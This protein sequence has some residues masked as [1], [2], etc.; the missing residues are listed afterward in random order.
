MKIIK[1]TDTVNHI[2]GGQL[3]LA[4]DSFTVP[5]D[6]NIKFINN[7]D[8]IASIVSGVAV[9]NDGVSDI[10]DVGLA[11]AF[12]NDTIAKEVVTQDEKS[13]RILKM[14]GGSV[15]V[16][17]DGTATILFKIPG[18]TGLTPPDGRW[19]YSFTGFF[20]VHTAGDK[21]VSAHITDEDNMLGGGAGAIIMSFTDDEAAVGNQGW[22]IPPSGEMDAESV[23]GSRFC[24]AGLWVKVVAQKG[25]GIASG[26]FYL[27][28]EW[29]KVS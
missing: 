23:A 10:G 2:W 16:A 9:I 28:A 19:I 3:I 24:P 8:L 20:D 5:A 12:L 1:N 22:F 18:T 4:G 29:G 15:A 13:N 6:K 14:A 21:I 26:I 7:S 11:V 25:G 27:N 17:L